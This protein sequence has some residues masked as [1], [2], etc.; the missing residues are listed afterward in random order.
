M[1]SALF[2]L[3]PPGG[4]RGK[5]VDRKTALESSARHSYNKRAAT[6]Q[7]GGSNVQ[8]KGTS[9]ATARNGRAVR[10]SPGSSIRVKARPKSNPVS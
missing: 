3:C 9:D 5:Y 7:V 2:T 1:S 6:L 8:R 4:W 10:H